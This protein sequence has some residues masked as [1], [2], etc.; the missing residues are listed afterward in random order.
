MQDPFSVPCSDCPAAI[1]H[2]TECSECQA[3]DGPLHINCVNHINGRY[4]FPT[5]FFRN[6]C[7]QCSFRAADLRLKALDAL[8]REFERAKQPAKKR[9]G[10][11]G[12]TL[13]RLL[14]SGW[15][16]FNAFSRSFAHEGGWGVGKITGKTFGVPISPLRTLEAA[17][18]GGGS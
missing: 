14:P 17:H 12:L 13:S 6:L 2:L 4:S 11:G 15:S 7:S 9:P 10:P 1:T 16:A 18:Q 8:K 5:N 3:C